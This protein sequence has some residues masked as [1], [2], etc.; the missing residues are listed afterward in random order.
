MYTEQAAANGVS[1][2]SMILPPSDH[3]SLIDVLERTDFDLV[4][5]PSRLTQSGNA[6]SLIHW[7]ATYRDANV[8]V[9][10]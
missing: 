8:L 7:I 2:N 5:I 3:C 10:L 1:F 9:C 6:E 4:V